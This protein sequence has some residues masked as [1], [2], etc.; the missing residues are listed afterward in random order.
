MRTASCTPST[1]S[2]SPGRVYQ[3][4]L[5]DVPN[6]NGL[7]ADDN[8]IYRISPESGHFFLWDAGDGPTGE[9]VGLRARGIGHRRGR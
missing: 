4:P 9:I 5:V 6:P 2:G 7:I 3:I 1:T 8:Q